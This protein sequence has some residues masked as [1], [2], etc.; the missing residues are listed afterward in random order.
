MEKRK[1]GGVG[2]LFLVT[3]LPTEDIIHRFTCVMLFI[4]FP[5]TCGKLQKNMTN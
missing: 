2:W 4:L 5:I 3:D 1:E